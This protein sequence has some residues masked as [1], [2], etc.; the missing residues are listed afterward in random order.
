MNLR[1]ILMIIITIW[2]IVGIGGSITSV[3]V[4]AGMSIGGGGEEKN[5]PVN[6]TTSTKASGD[7]SYI[8]PIILYSIIAIGVVGFFVY[9]K[10]VVKDA[11]YYVSAAVLVILIFY[12][13][14]F[15]ANR[16]SISITGG[17][18]AELGEP[19]NLSFLFFYIITGFFIG[20]ITFA[21]MG[22]FKRK[23][24]RKKEKFEKKEYREYVERAIYHVKIGEDVRGSILRAYKEM[25]NMMRRKGIVDREYYTPREFKNFALSKLN[26]SVKPVEN[27]TKLFEFARY[28]SHE[29]REEDR[30][31]AL[32]SLEMIKNELE[33]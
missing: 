8:F 25:E 21:I 23:V 33:K 6:E 32:S 29:M 24:E 15:L 16:V 3:N 11:L 17:G 7:L 30:E 13:L 5:Y 20:I 9:I 4:P 18:N 12:T 28:S 14:L 31:I 10:Y 26:L 1:K 2:I 22:A 27:L 19:Y